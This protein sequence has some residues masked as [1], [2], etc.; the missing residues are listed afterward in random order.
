MRSYW[1]E[2]ARLNAAFYVD[3]SL[4]Y[5]Q[6]DMDRFLAGGRA[7]V[8]EA[9]EHAPVAPPGRQTAVE[10][11]CG[12]GRVCIALRAHFEH[13]VGYDIA[14]EMLRQAQDLVSDPAVEL[15]LTDGASLPGLDDASV[16][17]VL[18][19]T[20]FQHI[21]DPE[22]IRSYVLEAG[23]VLRPDG[24]FVFQWNNTPGTRRWAARRGAMSVLQRLGGGDRYGRDRPEFLGS[25]V[26]LSAIDAWL[27]E[28]GLRRTGLRNPGEL[29]AWGWA[30]RPG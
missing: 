26:P 1:D 5:D 13:V 3:T 2:R 14:P 24:V 12:L 21:P 19:F 6:P 25:R 30:Q 16:D 29:F 22:V 8:R 27:V 18:T 28:G 23:R 11:G 15:R 17:L 7:I 4:A 20:V 10:I 9:L